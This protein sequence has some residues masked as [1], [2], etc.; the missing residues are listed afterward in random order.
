M[1]EDHPRPVG[2]VLLE[3]DVDAAGALTTRVEP[4]LTVEM[5][6]NRHVARRIPREDHAPLA[7]DA[8]DAELVSA[9][10]DTRLEDGNGHV[11][12]ADVVVARP[13]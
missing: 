11:H 12:P 9:T 5:P 13:P 3:A 6:G 4:E 1:L 8:V 10:A 2:T 7:F